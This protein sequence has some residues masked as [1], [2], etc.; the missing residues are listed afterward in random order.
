MPL[1]LSQGLSQPGLCHRLSF[2]LPQMACS[3]TLYLAASPLLASWVFL[4]TCCLQIPLAVDST[5]RLVALLEAFQLRHLEGH[6]RGEA[7][8]FPQNPG[9]ELEERNE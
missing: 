8:V 4:I 5:E 2:D 7:W 9:E 3:S 1:C 6:V